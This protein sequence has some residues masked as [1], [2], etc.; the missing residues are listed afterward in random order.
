MSRTVHSEHGVG[1]VSWRSVIEPTTLL[2]TA[3]ARSKDSKLSMSLCQHAYLIETSN[4]ELLSATHDV[5]RYDAAC[6]GRRA[7]GYGPVTALARGCDGRGI[8]LVF[9]GQ[10]R[11]F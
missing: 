3:I 4:L 7:A 6:P 1:S 2:A 9:P 11:G 5:N 10:R 8:P